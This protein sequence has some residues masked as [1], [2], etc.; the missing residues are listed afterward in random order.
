MFKPPA[1]VLGGSLPENASTSRPDKSRY[2]TQCAL[3][4]AVLLSSC[5]AAAAQGVVGGE[6]I[7]PRVAPLSNPKFDIL[8]VTVVG[9]EPGPFTNG[10]PPRGKIRID[11]VL[12]GEEKPRTVQAVWRGSETLND[13][14]PM[15]QNKDGRYTPGKLK[16]EWYTR[17]LAGPTAGYKLIIFKVDER[18]DGAFWIQ[19]S[20]VDSSENRA[21][22]LA[23][24]APPERKDW[25]QV[26][27]FLAL[28]ACPFLS[29]ACYLGW[30]KAS[31][32]P[33]GKRILLAAILLLPLIALLIY[34][35]Y[36]SGISIHSNI[37]IDVLLIW[38]ALAITFWFWLV[39]GISY[40]SARRRRSP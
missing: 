38:P 32:P 15:P 25:T 34:R 2:G 9:M 30:Q 12:R 5:L 10:N 11:E 24:M 16:P 19:Y 29:L 13:Y 35:Y 17:A 21:I 20:Y 31:V 18:S 33:V 4:L 26:A 27:A 1:A 6:R 39:L 28:L 23:R 8:V 40:L 37:R 7:D 22:V 3:L 14:D 36:E